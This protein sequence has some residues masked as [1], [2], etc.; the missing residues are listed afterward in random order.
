MID[1]G[2][3]SPLRAEKAVINT[4]DSVAQKIDSRLD[5]TTMGSKL[6]YVNT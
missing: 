3:N 6:S 4:Q 5:R 1:E 2:S